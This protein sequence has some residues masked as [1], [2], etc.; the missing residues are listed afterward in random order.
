LCSCLNYFVSHYIAP[1]P[2]DSPTEAPTT[3]ATEASDSADNGKVLDI[4]EPEEFDP[5][6]RDFQPPMEEESE[7]G[8][9]TGPIVGIAFGGLACLLGGL[10]IVMRRR[11]SDIEDDESFNRDKPIGNEY[12]E[13]SLYSG[14]SRDMK[15]LDGDYSASKHSSRSA[16]SIALGRSSF[17]QNRAK[18][19]AEATLEKI[20]DAIDTANWNEVYTLASEMAEHEDLSTLSSRQSSNRSAAEKKLFKSI[21][22]TR[23]SRTGLSQEDLERTQTLDDLV[24]IN[25]W[26]GLAVTAALYAGESASRRGES[27]QKRSLLDRMTGKRASSRAASAATASESSSIPYGNALGTFTDE[28]KSGSSADGHVDAAANAGSFDM[29]SQTSSAAELSPLRKDFD[30]AVESADWG[31]V[32]EL[33]K[34]FES[35]EAYQANIRS[36]ESVASSSAGAGF[37]DEESCISLHERLNQAV[38]QSDWSSV[39]IYATKMNEIYS[40]KAMSQSTAL[41]PVQPSSLLDDF[42]LTSIDTNGTGASKKQTIEKLIKAGKW[43]GASIMAGLY[44]MEAKGS[45]AP[46]DIPET[47]LTVST[48]A[49]GKSSSWA[50]ML[51]NTSAESS[52]MTSGKKKAWMGMVGIS[53]DEKSPSKPPQEPPGRSDNAVELRHSDRV[54]G[55]IPS[56]SSTSRQKKQDNQDDDGDSTLISMM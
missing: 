41:V 46:S 32:M 8:L 43:K 51:P 25:D 20:N 1:P 29:A 30:R 36:N 49:N 39:N 37:D 13:D 52:T 14:R 2:T 7:N 17:V 40:S 35:N 16:A 9:A 48:S 55:T 6:N 11:D 33:A 47:S 28:T 4:G 42:S 31:R 10:L 50:T 44:D 21:T 23:R 3:E 24:E 19:S 45:I 12:G 18:I 38:S 5:S 54:T 56:M 26:T 53:Q 27:S 15:V 34:A 22:Y